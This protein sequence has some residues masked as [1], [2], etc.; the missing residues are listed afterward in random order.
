MTAASARIEVKGL[1]EFQAA[2]R[3]MDA[4]LPKQIRLVLN[5]SGQLLVDYDQAH[6]PRKSGRA[7][8][9][10]KMRSSQRE[11][12]VAIGGNKAPYVPWLDFGGKGKVHGRPPRRP[13]MSDGRY[14][15]QGLKVHKQDITELMSRGLTE[16]AQ[17]AGVE[18]T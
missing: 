5:A 11:A 10:V 6:M 1:R 16:L 13:Y 9:S 8:A 12:R 15:Y 7:V 2:L 3:Q 18:V 4:G 17:S 14:T